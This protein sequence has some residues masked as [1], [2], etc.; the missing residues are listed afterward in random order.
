MNKIYGI[1]CIIVG[2]IMFE[3][4]LFSVF[5]QSTFAK[6]MEQVISL[7]VMFILLAA[8]GA[9]FFFLLWKIGVLQQL[10]LNFGDKRDD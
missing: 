1:L 2:T 5:G 8:F 4:G 3:Y 9:G 7:N 6:T 10:D